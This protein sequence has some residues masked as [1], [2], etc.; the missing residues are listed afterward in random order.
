MSVPDIGE[1]GQDIQDVEEEADFLAEHSQTARV[2]VNS[3]RSMNRAIRHATDNMLDLQVLLPLGL[4]AVTFFEIGAA[5][6]PLWVT[7]GIFSFNSFI[8]LHSPQP[9]GPRSQ[10][11]VRE[12]LAESQRETSIASQTRAAS[13]AAATA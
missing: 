6:T 13:S 12:T 10:R 3:F 7:L 11:A 8:S 9:G 5:A 4:A 2:I 1:G